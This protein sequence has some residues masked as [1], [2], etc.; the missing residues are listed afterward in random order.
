ITLLSILKTKDS[1][2]DFEPSVSIPQAETNPF[3]EAFSSE[4]GNNSQS[5]QANELVS[6]SAS[7]I[8]SSSN[9]SQLISHLDIDSR[10]YTFKNGLYKKTFL[11]IS[12]GKEAEMRLDCTI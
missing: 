2:S 1:N 3:S 6:E 8:A 7:E 12:E 5:N 10:I 4:I 11:P 9:Q